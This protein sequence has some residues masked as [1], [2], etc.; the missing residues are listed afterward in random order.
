MNH[1]ERKHYDD[2]KLHL[3]NGHA[4]TGLPSSPKNDIV[5]LKNIS[6]PEID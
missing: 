5:P 3:L 1:G 6:L 4:N 2:D